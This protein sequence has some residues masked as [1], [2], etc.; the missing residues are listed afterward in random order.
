MDLFESL[1]DK[2]NGKN[3][4]IVFPE[5]EDP[6]VLGAAVRL[7][8]DGLIQAIVLGN[9]DKIQTLAAAKSWDLSKLTVH[10]PANDDIHA[11]MVAAFVERR[12]GKATPEQAEKIV[13]DANYF[14]TMLV[15][16]KEA[17]GMVSGAVHS[18]ADT[19]RPAL[20][21]IKT[22]PGVHLVS[23]AFIMQRGRDERYLFAD[24]AINID[25]DADQLAEIAVESAK[26]AA[27]FDIEPPRVA[28]LSFST[29]GSAKGLQVDKVV[30]ATKKAHE[31]APDL[32][33]DGELQ[34][35]AAFVPSV[36]KQ[37][38]PDSKVAGEA[39]VFIFPELQSGNIGYK[40]AQRF[41]GFEAIGPI[42]QGLNQPV[43]DL[44]R[45]ANEE[46]VYKLAIITAAQTL[47]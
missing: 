20:Q 9:P 42:L 41:G 8:A 36:A 25:P 37:K 14:G 15:Y 6:R 19:V 45:G 30:E 12:K 1:K 38:A 46:D 27:L 29:K 33:L 32:A 10:D 7:A 34:F 17:D 47:L 28:L 35:D 22:R 11:K 26:T 43:S 5:G 23:G 16:M 39:N 44:S 24:N 2:I 3:L 31:L 21:I 18:T 4:R 13:Q 40:I